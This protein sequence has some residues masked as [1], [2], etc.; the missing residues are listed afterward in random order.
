MNAKKWEVELSTLKSNNSRL[1]AA[2]Q[3][4]TA[5]VEEWKKQLQA[6][7]EENQR[8]KQR[9]LE[10]E[11]AR[12]SLTAAGELRKEISLMRDKIDMCQQQLK[13]KEEE[14]EMMKEKIGDGGSNSTSKVFIFNLLYLEKCFKR[15]MILNIYK[16][17]LVLYSPRFISNANF[18]IKI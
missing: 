9:T 8:L 10:A 13:N 2:L 4:S 6:Y 12:G 3:E 14:L 7:K 1:T 15:K 5:N 17:Y 11:A 16:F 18:D